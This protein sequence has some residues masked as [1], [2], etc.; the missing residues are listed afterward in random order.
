MVVSESKVREG[1]QEVE[2]FLRIA[3]APGTLN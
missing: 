3:F 1:L 2:G